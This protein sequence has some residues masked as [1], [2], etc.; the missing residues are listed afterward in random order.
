VE[1][2]RGIFD[3]FNKGL[4][5]SSADIVC[6]VGAD[7]YF[8]EDFD[9]YNVIN[10]MKS[11]QIVLPRYKYFY[12][13]KIKRNIFYKKYNYWH[14]FIGIPFYHPGTFIKR[15]TALKNEFKISN[16][17]RYC[18]DFIYFWGIMRDRPKI[19]SLDNSVFVES[20]GASGSWSSRAKN[21]YAMIL[22][23]PVIVLCVFPFFFLVRYTYKIVQLR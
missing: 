8:D 4:M 7:D 12:K 17:Y 22:A 3:G 13:N 1:N 5:M 20:G 10:K 14:Y 11:F 19:T 21:L 15:Q 16:T 9:F 18:A 2:D 23:L 6:M